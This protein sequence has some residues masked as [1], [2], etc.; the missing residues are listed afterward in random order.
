[1]KPEPQT[2]W[3]TMACDCGFT[4]QGLI[5]SE[6]THDM[7]CVKCGNLMQPTQEAK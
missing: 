6:F 2:E 7:P 4:F 1:M 5:G 3:V